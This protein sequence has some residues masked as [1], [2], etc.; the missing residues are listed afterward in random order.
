MSAMLAV[1][2]LLATV[3]ACIG[4]LAGTAYTD[5]ARERAYRQ[6]V[7][8]RRELNAMLLH[9]LDSYTPSSYTPFQPGMS[10][11]ATLRQ[12]YD[13]HLGGD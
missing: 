8:E 4:F 9:T 3:L 2:A 13:H 6:L 12:P 1:A 10:R 11:Q 7:H 5:R